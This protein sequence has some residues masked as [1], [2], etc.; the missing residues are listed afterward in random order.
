MAQRAR[1]IS[2]ASLVYLGLV[3]AAGFA[4]GVVRVLWLAPQLGDRNAELFELPLMVA[5]SFFAAR[6]VLARFKP[7]RVA[8][9][10]VIGL[11]ALM[12]LVAL[13]LT[14]VLA[15]QGWSLQEYL[16]RRDPVSGIAYLVSLLIY[17]AMPALLA[18]RKALR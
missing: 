7:G 18:Q 17:A 15:V 8:D 4:L 12:M 14:L 13:E 9:C 10:T 1:T 3:F 5:I 16:A 2:F 11:L 6:F